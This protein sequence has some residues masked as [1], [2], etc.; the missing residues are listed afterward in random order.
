MK[1]PKLSKKQWI[2]ASA[3]LL[4]LL[5]AGVYFYLQYRKKKQV[6]ALSRP[7]EAPV[8][9][10]LPDTTI[11]AGAT[12]NVSIGST[13][14]KLFSDC[15]ND[16]FPLKYGKCGKRVEQ[17]Q[18]YLIRTYGAQFS[19]YGVD[20]KWGD[21]TETIAKKFILKNEPFSISEDYFNKTGMA[22]IQTVKYA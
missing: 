19:T 2:I 6:D 3:I 11:M 20:G 7:G 13:T 10:L 21:E 4:L 12:T 18:I 22:Y 9:P 16:S 14:P 1:M 15:P 5:A 8:I 17:F